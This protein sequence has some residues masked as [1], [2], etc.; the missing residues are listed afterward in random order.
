MTLNRKITLKRDPSRF[1][2]RALLSFPKLSKAQKNI[3]L[4]ICL[5]QYHNWNFPTLLLFV[6]SANE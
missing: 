4:F 3:I 6:I 2:G 1:E 5:L